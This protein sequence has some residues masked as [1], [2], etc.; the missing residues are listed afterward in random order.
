METEFWAIFR[1]PEFFWGLVVLI[2]ISACNLISSIKKIP[3][4]LEVI[5]LYAILCGFFGIPLLYLVP[6][7]WEPDKLYPYLPGLFWVFW[8]SCGSF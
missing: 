8:K 5:R 1:V 6:K 7:A 3:P 2:F 4:D